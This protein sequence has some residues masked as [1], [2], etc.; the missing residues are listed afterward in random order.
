MKRRFALTVAILSLSSFAGAAWMAPS[1]AQA[2]SLT[3]TSAANSA[4]PFLCIA[5]TQLNIGVC[6]S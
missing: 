4:K 3:S 5:V 1:P 6:E 2:S